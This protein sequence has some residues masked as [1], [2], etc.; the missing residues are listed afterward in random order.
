MFKDYVIIDNFFDKPYQVLEKFQNVSY[1]TKENR[2]LPGI[3]INKEKP[4]FSTTGWRGYRS[5]F[6]SD[7]DQELFS[8]I[9]LN[10]NK[11][12]F[13]A[14]EFNWK[15]QTFFHLSPEWI[16]EETRWWHRDPFL[17]AGVIYLNPNSN[18]DIGTLLEIDD[19]H[20]LIENKF[21]RL[22]FYRGE[23]NHKPNKLV[24]NNYDTVRKTISIFVEKLLLG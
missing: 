11:K 3:K 17:L 7:I 12:V 20:V 18:L 19:K 1:F 23:L 13:F 16:D 5:N 22:A 14:K 6:I 8:L 2:D 21:N 15:A 10:M 4:S 9:S 24:G